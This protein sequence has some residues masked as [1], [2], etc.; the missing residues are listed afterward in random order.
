MKMERSVGE[1]K[2]STAKVFGRNE[3]RPISMISIERGLDANVPQFVPRRRR[4]PPGLVIVTTYPVRL[5]VAY[6]PVR[7]I[8]AALQDDGLQ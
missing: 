8:D 3:P 2:Y 6:S 7:V 4:R 1:A 5:V